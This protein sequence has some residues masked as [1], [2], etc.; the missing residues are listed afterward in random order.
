MTALACAKEIALWLTVAGYSCWT[1]HQLATNF[2]I[3]SC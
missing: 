2:A 1:V 3:Q